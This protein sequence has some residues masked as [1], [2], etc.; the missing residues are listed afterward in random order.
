MQKEITKY[1]AWTGTEMLY[2]VIPVNP[3]AVI[4]DMQGL[5][6]E[7]T[8]LY[9]HDIKEI[10]P[11]TGHKDA[12]GKDIYEGDVYRDTDDEAD[13]ELYFVCTWI[14][15]LCM[16]AWL[17]NDEYILYSGGIYSKEALYEELFNDLQS[18]DS[19]FLD[20]IKIIGNIYERPKLLEL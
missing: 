10:M 18:I 4:T 5:P 12:N 7:A 8:V 17:G 2:D 3:S 19:K 14:K 20:G 11:C 9:R 16:F 1:R 15:E 13:R 6:P